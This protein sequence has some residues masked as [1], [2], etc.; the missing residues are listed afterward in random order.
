[1]LQNHQRWWAGTSKRDWF[2]NEAVQAYLVAAARLLSV[3]QKCATF[4][5]LV[6]GTPAAWVVG[7]IDRHQYFEYIG[8]YNREFAAYS[9]GTL[10]DIMVVKNLLEMDVARVHLGPGLDAY[11]RALG[12]RTFEFTHVHGYKGWR[13][14]VLRIA[15]ALRR[16]RLVSWNTEAK[17]GMDGVLNPGGR[18]M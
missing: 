18:K 6:D 16:L 15:R 5:L 1:M 12:G 13:R 7:A 17:G 4:T 2:G 8:S 9:P 10:L 11:K 14:P 3:Q